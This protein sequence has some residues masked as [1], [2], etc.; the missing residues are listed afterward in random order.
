MAESHP[1]IP[2]IDGVLVDQLG[3]DNNQ[4]PIFSQEDEQDLFNAYMGAPV[5]NTPQEPVNDPAADPNAPDKFVQAYRKMQ[6]EADQAKARLQQLEQELM[7]SK[8]ELNRKQDFGIIDQVIQSDP[9]L[10]QEVFGLIE[11]ASSGQS[12]EPAL[13]DPPQPPALPNADDLLDPEKL[14][15]FQNDQLRYQQELVDYNRKAL[16]QQIEARTQPFQ[17]FLQNQQQQ[18]AIQQQAQYLYGEAIQSG[19]Q[20]SQA[21]ELVQMFMQKEYFEPS[22]YITLYKAAKGIQGQAQMTQQQLAAQRARQ[23]QFPVPPPAS[24][25]TQVNPV[26]AMKTRIKAFGNQ[27]ILPEVRA[28]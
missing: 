8:Q 1:T 19:L 20:P 5:E 25:G 14:R 18:Q 16:E 9:R 27:S 28:R 6:S 22:E 11:K 15:Q 26:E 4:Q 12:S 23:N 7:Q 2:G 10:A 3:Q 21:S 17:Q 13:P 24:M